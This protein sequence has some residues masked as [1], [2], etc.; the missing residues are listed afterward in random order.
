MP[1]KVNYRADIDGLRCFA[2]WAVV[3]YHTNHIIPS[4]FLGVDVFFVIS[5][6]LITSLILREFEKTGNISFSNFYYRRARRILP[7]FYLISI[8]SIIVFYFFLTSS[9]YIDLAQS[10]IANNFFMSNFFF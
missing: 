9:E 3:L 1:F 4:G 8:F 7:N 10:V 6:F 2:V 5:G